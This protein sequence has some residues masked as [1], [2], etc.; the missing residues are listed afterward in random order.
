MCICKST[1]CS[2][3][4]ICAITLLALGIPAS[5]S[6]DSGQPVH[7]LELAD[8]GVRFEFFARDR[9]SPSA[10]VAA[11][12]LKH[13]F[14]PPEACIQTVLPLVEPALAS[15][16]GTSN[17]VPAPVMDANQNALPVMDTNSLDRVWI[18]LNVVRDGQRVSSSARLQLLHHS[19]LAEPATADA[20]ISAEASQDELHRATA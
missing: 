11:Q 8:Y 17:R 1:P 18:D 12:C 13:G 3:L 4:H 20:I 7:V 10:A 14:H 16:F 19:E 6:A 9:G 2:G 15:R 5:L